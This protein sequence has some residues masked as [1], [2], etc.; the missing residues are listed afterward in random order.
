M[1]SA[2]LSDVWPGQIVLDV[3]YRDRDL[4]RSVPGA[5]WIRDRLWRVPCT[6][7]VCLAMRGVFGERLEIG[8]ALEKWAWDELRGRV[9]PAIEARD[10]AMDPANSWI[11]VEPICSPDLWDQL[12]SYQR[13][14]ARFLEVAG[15]AVLADDM[16][17]GKTVE[18]IATLERCSS[19]PA[20]IV[21]PK[22]VKENWREAFERWA[23]HREVSLVGTGAGKA[24]ALAAEADVTIVNY[25]TLRT[26]SRIAGYG[27]IRLTPAERQDKALNRP[28]G[29]VVADEAH[30]A[31]DPK[32]K[33]TRA[34]W[35]VGATAQRRLALTGTPIANS[36][37]DFWSLLHFVAPDE[38]PSRSTYLDRYC[39][40]TA[41]F[42][43][44]IEILGLR[45]D[46]KDEFYASVDCRLLRRPKELVASDLPPK[47]YV[48]R[49]AP[50][51]PKQERAYKAM[52]DDMV[53]WLDKD[54]V[55]AFDPLV[56]TT[57][58]IQFASS[59]A[60]VVDGKVKLAAPSGKIDALIELLDEMG[61]EPLVVF[62]QSRQLIDLACAALSKPSVNISH[63]RI[64]G[65]ETEAQR[66]AAR[67]D[68]RRGDARVVLLTLGAGS[69]GL[70]GLQD[71]ASTV[72][73]LQRSYS[74]IENR[75]AEDRLHRIGQENPVTVIDLI[76]PGTVEETAVLPAVE[77]KADML[78]EIV[79][80]RA[81][82]R[83]LIAR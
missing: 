40:V 61:D 3:E 30:R 16:G 26:A 10:L 71:R 43:G 66:N 25:E 51:A 75:Q 35:A 6:W 83:R 11:Q 21:C 44:G 18:T 62:A 76:T 55:A 59:Y 36:P 68:F 28:W 27:S 24:R 33:T 12:R 67:A 4:V 49:Y 56:Q 45:P 22:G 69:T 81:A 2:D 23:P 78:E 19:Y 58:L 5:K 79:R 72:C 20:L 73:F 17:L 80:D 1:A 14:G 47:Q 53:A 31:K 8:E 64:T 46:T 74:L 38:W 48:V 42:W 9:E 39:L 82:L 7:A 60:E 52:V 15:S 13:T 63:V 70:D 50:M 32:A 54:A 77:G 37:E 65:S 57:R 41:G 34:L 29:A